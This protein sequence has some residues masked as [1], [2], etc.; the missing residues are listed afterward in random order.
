MEVAVNSIFLRPFLA[1]YCSALLCVGSSA[2]FANGIEENSF[3]G[4]V[5]IEQGNNVDEQVV[6]ELVPLAEVVGNFKN[7]SYYLQR[8]HNDGYY[9]LVAFSDTGDIVQLHDASKWQIA[10]SGCQKVL[11]W[12]QSDDIFI[13]P[14]VA[15][16]SF[17]KYVLH[18]RT[19][20]QAVE[21]TLINP[22]L[23]MGAYTFR[24]VNVEPYQR[25]VLLSDNTVWQVNPKDMNFSQ[26]KV[27]QRLLVGVNNRWRT[28]PYPHILINVDMDGEP[29]SEAVF[30][31]YPAE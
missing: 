5:K 4:V 23:P 9:H 16:F 7:D 25:L 20:N 22:P 8:I 29:F 24:I 12:V 18:N 30:Y 27:G 1:V 19:I 26:W 28:E 13:K 15:C 10:R 6:E 21:A 14:C 31:G 17:N 11:Y 3:P 2:I